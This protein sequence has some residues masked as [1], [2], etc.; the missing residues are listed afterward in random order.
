MRS[1]SLALAAAAG[2]AACGNYSTDDVAFIEAMPTREALRVAVPPQPP[3]PT[4]GALGAASEWTQARA[5]GDGMNAGLD[6]IL[7]VVDLVRSTD[8]TQ[9]HRDARVWGPFPD[10]NHPGFQ[11]RVRIDRSAGADGIPSYAFSF[12]T[13]GGA[14]VDWTALIDGRFVGASGRTGQGS[15]TLHFGIIRAL[16]LSQKPDDPTVDVTILYDRRGDPRWLSLSLPPSSAGFGLVDFDY[17]YYSWTSGDA[18]LD[19]ALADAQ[20]TRIVKQAGFLPSGAGRADVTI[21]PANPPPTSYQFT[22]CWDASGCISA[23]ADFFN[24]SGIC[25]SAPCVVGWPA[26]CPQVLAPPPPL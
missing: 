20:G 26:G 8:P 14:A 7:G 11:V 19:F 21:F 13:L 3:P 2:L 10:G 4:C 1:R 12:E 22:V 23:V 6:W 24:V 15:V 25:A 5:S 16:G 9:R 18:H 17:R